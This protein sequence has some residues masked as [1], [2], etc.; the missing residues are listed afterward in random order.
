MWFGTPKSEILV[1]T[2]VNLEGFSIGFREKSIKMSILDEILWNSND[3]FEQKCRT[4]VKK[5]KNDDLWS[6]SEKS[7]FIS[8]DKK[9]SKLTSKFLSESRRLFTSSSWKKLKMKPMQLF[10]TCT[11]FL[12]P[13]IVTSRTWRKFKSYSSF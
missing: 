6:K 1:P 9:P 2:G 11:T 8:I 13:R 4:R 5:V 7:T 3:N 10:H 12:L